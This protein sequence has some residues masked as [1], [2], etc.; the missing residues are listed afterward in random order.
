MISTELDK[1]YINDTTASDGYLKAKIRILNEEA[2]EEKQG[3]LV[4]RYKDA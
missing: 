2:G 1:S 4:F 3:Q